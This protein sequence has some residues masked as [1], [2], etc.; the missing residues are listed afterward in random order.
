MTSHTEF[1]R[2]T[3]SEQVVE[4]FSSQ[5]KGKTILITGVSPN[6]LA[7]A[8]VLALATQSPSMLI[9]TA[10]SAEKAEA[11][12]RKLKAEHPSVKYQVLT[13]DLSVQKSIREAAAKV[14]TWTKQVDVLINNAGV[15]AIPERT[16][17]EDGI[18]MHFAT[19]FL[20]HFLFTNLLIHAMPSGGRI[21]NIT[22]AGYKVTPIRFSDYN[23]DG[24]PVPPSEQPLY[25]V[26]AELGMPGLEK[27]QGYVPFLAYM[28]SNTANMLFTIGLAG[29]LKARGV[30][31]FSAA[32]GV[33]ITELQRHIGGFRN[34]VM[35]YK[36]PSQGAATFLVA[37]LNPELDGVD[38]SGAFLDDCHIVA[39]VGHA[40]DVVSAE[41][42]WSLGE[43][44]VGQKFE[45]S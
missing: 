6:G 27:S 7:E 12:A 38:F 20:G 25:D 8:M 45:F 24:K 31:S 23:F 18:E 29:K 16:L 1:D 17:S 3:T 13:L 34:P 10:R 4:A 43:K 21:V 37:A 42:L 2:E 40:G 28:H 39:D 36:T 35:Q 19:N 11:V 15:M 41:K 32:P 26:A 5:I 22:S 33:V 14:L 44:L 30:R 9:L